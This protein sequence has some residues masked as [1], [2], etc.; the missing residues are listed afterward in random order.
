MVFEHNIRV[1]NKVSVIL[2]VINFY[3]DVNIKVD[4]TVKVLVREIVS[5]PK[6]NYIG[7]KKESS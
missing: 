3:L 6:D 5:K 4:S 1:L 2:V 7:G